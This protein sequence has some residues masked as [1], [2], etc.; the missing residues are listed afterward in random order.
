MKSKDEYLFDFSNLKRNHQFNRPAPHKSIYYLA[1]IDAI[2]CG[3][4][5]SNQFTLIPQLKSKFI[6]YWS[7]FVGDDDSY[8]PDIYTPAFYCDTDPFY[9]LVTHDQVS[10]KNWSS[11]KGF[12]KLYQY[13]EID[14][15]LFQYI[16]SDSS[17][18]AKLR[19]ILVSSLK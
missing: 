6:D 2:T 12:S 13:I 16:R 7:C 11:D 17:F 5:T 1:L 10:K 18:A 8:K 3:F 9:R 14:E 15:D 4:L 19:V